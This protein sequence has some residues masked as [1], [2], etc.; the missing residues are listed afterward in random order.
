LTGFGGIA[1]T[2]SFT[3]N[4]GADVTGS[5]NVFAPIVNVNNGAH[6]Q[7]GIL[8]V[9]SGGTV[10]VA[11]GTY[12]ESPIIRKSLTLRGTA[13]PSDTIIN[14]LDGDPYVLQ[15][16]ASD[17][18]VDGF[19]ITN[20]EYTGGSDPTAILINEDTINKQPFH[21]LRITNNW[22]HDIGPVTRNPASYGTG[23]IV[24][25]S[26]LDIEIDHNQFYNLWNA[27]SSSDNKA[28]GINLNS[29]NVPT[30]FDTDFINIHDNT[31]KDIYSPST[32]DAGIRVSNIKSSA[33]ITIQ[34]NVFINTGDHG[35]WFRYPSTGGKVISNNTLIGGSTG[36]IGIEINSFTDDIHDNIITGYLR[37]IVADAGSTAVPKV[38][39]NDLSGNTL[40]LDNRSGLVLVLDASGN[41]WGDASGPLDNSTM[42]DACGLTLTNP[43]GTGSPVSPCVIY[44]PWLMTDPFAPPPPP[45]IVVPPVSSPKIVPPSG[46]VIRHTKANPFVGIVGQIIPVTGG[47]MTVLSCSSSSTQLVLNGIIITF[48]GLCGYS[49][50]ADEVVEAGLPAKLPG[51]EAFVS[52]IAFSLLKNGQPITILPDGAL[53]QIAYPIPAGFEGKTFTVLFWDGAKWVDV[54]A[55]ISSGYATVNA[56][57]SGTFILAAK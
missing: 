51:S 9:S 12:N 49:V 20:P 29:T 5:S 8:L 25:R 3:L 53:V 1:T 55:S 40:G 31:F 28:F 30:W 38:Y 35:I 36:L 6:I 50:V 37:G 52:G 14:G 23:G 18:T 2:D 32:S 7:D 26:G 33:R 46:D 42:P 44:N 57:N 21:H 11:A 48:D 39:G 47:A 15:I 34:N 45:P 43:D 54:A 10:N 4:S 16:F 22:L 13:G 24:V 56:P 17:V 19:S 27:D 41:W